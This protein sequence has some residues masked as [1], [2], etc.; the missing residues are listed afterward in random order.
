VFASLATFILLALG[1]WFV[2]STRLLWTDFLL[3][4]VAL[5]SQG[6][7]GSLAEKWAGQMRATEPAI[8]R[9]RVFNSRKEHL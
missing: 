2:Q 8:S 6:V 9:R 4:G 3:V 7:L 1:Y 5:L